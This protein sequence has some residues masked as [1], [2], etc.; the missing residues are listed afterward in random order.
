MEGISGE[1]SLD[2]H[3]TGKLQDLRDAVE[4]LPALPFSVNLWTVQN[5]CYELLQS[6]WIEKR[7][8]AE[9]GDTASAQWCEQFREICEAL[10]IFV[11]D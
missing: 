6:T 9:K 10:S 4:L 3:D 2:P 5:I 8:A 11:K 1:L 7:D